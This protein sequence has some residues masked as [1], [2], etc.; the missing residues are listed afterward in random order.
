MHGISL[1]RRI[2][3]IYMERNIEQKWINLNEQSQI[4]QQF[5]VRVVFHRNRVLFVLRL[6]SELAR[7][8]RRF[9]ESV[10]VQRCFADATNSGTGR[11]S[12][13]KPDFWSV[14]QIFRPISRRCLRLVSASH[15]SECLGRI[16]DS[17]SFLPNELGRSFWFDRTQ[18][19]S[20]PRSI[21]HP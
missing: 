4:Y 7:K 2:L 5:S 17:H 12:F 14:W 8:R 1:I 11:S 9:Q 20:F 13:P 16:S 19:R 6:V 10:F 21:R 18:R 3:T 15:R